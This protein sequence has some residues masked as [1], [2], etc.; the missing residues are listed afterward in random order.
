MNHA[1]NA[2]YYSLYV[3]HSTSIS[4]PI[5][6]SI[7][8]SGAK[9]G[10]NGHIFKISKG[11]FLIK[12]SQPV[13]SFEEEERFGGKW[14]KMMSMLLVAPCEPRSRYSLQGLTNCPSERTILVR[15]QHQW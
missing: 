13:G 5:T 10:D 14:K 15:R 9:Y 12:I 1:S 7:Y 2:D 11:M 8:P 6:M 3:P 4:I